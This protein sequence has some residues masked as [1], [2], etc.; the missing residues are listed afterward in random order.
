V[1]VLDLP[2]SGGKIAQDGRPVKLLRKF[3]VHE[4][5]LR[6]FKT[7]SRDFLRAFQQAVEKRVRS[8]HPSFIGLS[9][10]YD[11]G[12]IQV[13][14]KRM[15]QS[16][17]S[18]T[19]FSTEDMD[20]IQRRIEWTGSLVEANIIILSEPDRARE[21]R[22]L[23]EHSEHFT[24]SGLGRQGALVDDPASHGLSHIF[25][26][27]RQRGILVYLSGTGAD[28]VI[29]DYG[30]GGRKFFPHSSFGGLF[31]EELS[32]VFPWPSFFL[33]T[34]RDYLMK[35]ELVA[36]AHGIEGRYPF[37]DRAVVQ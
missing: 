19:I 34:Q 35:E 29:S 18:Y 5:D 13:A 1:I 27:V 10:G 30:H 6:Q 28:E 14:L 11:S 2:V 17:A 12:A 33:G 3:A 8:N 20:I 26:E 21:E 4:F 24:F 32:E 15:G 23:R 36:G 9:S 37:L 25:R 22:F 31:P 16:H 7:D